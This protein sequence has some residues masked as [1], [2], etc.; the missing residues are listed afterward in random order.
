MIQEVLKNIKDWV[1]VQPLAHKEWRLQIMNYY[2]KQM[3]KMIMI[4]IIETKVLLTPMNFKDAIRLV[5]FRRG[6]DKKRL[7]GQWLYKISG[8]IILKPEIK[9]THDSMLFR[10]SIWEIL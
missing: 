2:Q 10:V 4:K 8:E 5:A 3:Q 6:L 7:A 9:W 1:I